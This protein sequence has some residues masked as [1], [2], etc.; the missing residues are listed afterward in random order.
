[1]RLSQFGIVKGGSSFGCVERTYVLLTEVRKEKAS[2]ARFKRHVR[3][4]IQHLASDAID[5]EFHV[6]VRRIDANV[7]WK[8]T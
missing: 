8:I 2:T 1:M 5:Q 7:V 4:L 6:L 3:R